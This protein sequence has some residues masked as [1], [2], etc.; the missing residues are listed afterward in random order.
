MKEEW[1]GRCDPLAA[2]WYCYFISWHRPQVSDGQVMSVSFSFLLWHCS[3]LFFLLLFFFWCKMIRYCI[4]PL[5][6]KPMKRVRLC[7]L[8]NFVE[9]LDPICLVWKKLKKIGCFNINFPLSS[10]AWI[11]V[12]MLAILHSSVSVS[13][14]MTTVPSEVGLQFESSSCLFARQ[15]AAVA[16][17]DAD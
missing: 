3:L 6:V 5:L 1:E 11:S 10:C 13:I 12:C 15:P 8:W 4:W 16:V 2:I 17:C 14:K 9:C 7:Q